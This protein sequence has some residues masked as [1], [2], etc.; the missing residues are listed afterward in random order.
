MEKN[1]NTE[2]K[3]VKRPPSMLFMSGKVYYDSGWDDIGVSDWPKQEKKKK[4]PL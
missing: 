4:S 1:P 3:L 2:K